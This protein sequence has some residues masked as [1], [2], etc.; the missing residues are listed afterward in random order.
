[1]ISL[2]C[3]WKLMGLACRW[4]LWWLESTPALLI[5]TFQYWRYFAHWPSN[6]IL[7]EGPGFLYETWV[8]LAI[9]ERWWTIRACPAWQDVLC[10]LIWYVVLKSIQFVFLGG[11]ALQ[12][13]CIACSR[14][15]VLEWVAATDLEE[16][17]KIEVLK[18]CNC[19]LLIVLFKL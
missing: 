17:A 15:L 18:R 12:H 19:R 7:M 3:R 5:L 6:I 4:K 10:P 11:Q 8:I 1:M 2:A 16:H 13:A 14:K 9:S